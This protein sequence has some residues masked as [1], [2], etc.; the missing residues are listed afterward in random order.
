M[1]SQLSQWAAANDGYLFFNALAYGSGGSALTGFSLRQANGQWVGR[2]GETTESIALAGPSTRIDIPIPHCSKTFKSAS[3]NW[4]TV[5]EV[6]TATKMSYEF[7]YGQTADSD[8]SIGFSANGSSGW[9]IGGTRHIGNSSSTSV[10]WTGGEDE[11]WRLISV[12]HYGKYKWGGDYPCRQD[13]EVDPVAWN[14]GTDTYNSAIHDLDYHCQDYPVSQ[15]ASFN[16]G[17]N[18][19]RNDS[20]FVQFSGAATVFGASL[21]GQSGSSTFVQIHYH[22]INSRMICGNDAAPPSAHRIY[23]GQS[24]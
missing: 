9:S 11:G 8:L 12:F 16:P 1:D 5:G 20:D 7:T 24:G 17:A 3:D 10:Q 23:A 21:K 22:F 14:S 6:H 18:F 2:D 13:Y 15:R 19:D 4:T